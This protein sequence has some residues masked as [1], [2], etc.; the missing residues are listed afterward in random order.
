M[1]INITGDAPATPDVM[2]VVNVPVETLEGYD[3][4]PRKNDK[5]V[6]DMAALIQEFGFRQPILVRGNQIVDGHLRVKAALSLKMEH[7]PAID[8][9]D[10]SDTKIRAL[11]IS[12]NK[13]AEFAEWDMGLLSKEFEDLKMDGFDL[14]LT[15]FDDAALKKLMEPEQKTTK[16][17]NADAGTP[18]D[19][20]Y[21]SMSFHTTADN[22]KNVIG[23]LNHIRMKNGSTNVSAALVEICR[24]LAAEHSITWQGD[25]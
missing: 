15:G 19:P 7:V 2:T 11:R 20:N 1:P 23:V 17:K 18:A 25:D 4:N 5:A 14:N 10:M 22:R 21:V 6:P 16:S 3:N 8:V 24:D 9:G 13:A 12:M